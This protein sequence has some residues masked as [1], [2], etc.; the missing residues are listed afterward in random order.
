M[1]KPKFIELFGKDYNY[2]VNTSCIA[3]L[4]QSFEPGQP[5]RAILS[6]DGKDGKPA[7]IEFED[8]F[9]EI[10]AAINKEENPA[11]KPA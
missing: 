6:I 11:A 9:E 3:F 8:D 7:V 1:T 4:Q 5:H 10:V 2:H